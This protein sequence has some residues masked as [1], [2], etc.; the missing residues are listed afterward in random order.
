[1]CLYP[2][3]ISS[4]TAGSQPWVCPCVCPWSVC[5][6]VCPTLCLTLCLVCLPAGRGTRCAPRDVRRA[7]ARGASECQGRGSQRGV[8]PRALHQQSRGTAR[9]QPAPVWLQPVRYV[10]LAGARG[11]PGLGWAGGTSVL[12]TREAV[13]PVTRGTSAA[14]KALECS[15][16]FMSAHKA[17]L[18]FQEWGFSLIPSAETCPAA[19]GSLESQFQFRAKLC[20][21]MISSK[22]F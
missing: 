21:K 22:V 20:P 16:A 18:C 14:H 10:G 8:A 12:L 19:V 4:G 15:T 1:M 17:W 11:Q 5:L 7:C 6:S 3:R 9:A 13:C 2:A